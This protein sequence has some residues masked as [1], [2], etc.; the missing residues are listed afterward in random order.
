M[1][2]E[3]SDK[4]RLTKGRHESQRD[5]ETGHYKPLSSNE[6]KN[7]KL[8]LGILLLVSIVSSQGTSASEKYDYLTLNVVEY[9]LSCY[10]WIPFLPIQT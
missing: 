6:L 2:G 3:S 1:V 7:E 4:R 9:N 8:K 10:P 5:P